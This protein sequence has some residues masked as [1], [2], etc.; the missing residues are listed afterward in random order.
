MTKAAVA[1]WENL[2]AKDWLMCVCVC[3]RVVLKC[4]KTRCVTEVSKPEGVLGDGNPQE[5]AQV[6]QHS[7]GGCACPTLQE[8]CYHV[9]QHKGVKHLQAVHCMSHPLRCYMIGAHRHEH[10]R[11]G[12]VQSSEGVDVSRT[13]NS[14]L[15][16]S[17]SEVASWTVQE[18]MLC[19]YLV[20]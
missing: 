13:S 3:L 20:K 19:I 5:L 10:L 1:R 7:H 18:R 4:C 12:T 14:A 15:G 8:G 17:C 16:V 6:V 2:V 9:E 11:K